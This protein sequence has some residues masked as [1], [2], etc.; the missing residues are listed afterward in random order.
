[1]INHSTKLSP[2]FSYSNGSFLRQC[3]ETTK[4]T[5][6]DDSMGSILCFTIPFPQYYNCICC[7][8][9]IFS[10][11][12]QGYTQYFCFPIWYLCEEAVSSSILVFFVPICACLKVWIFMMMNNLQ[13]KPFNELNLQY[14]RQT[15][16]GKN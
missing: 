15:C 1:M 9:L 6:V 12:L 16:R 8:S 2:V 5:T 7:W 4:L 10:S 3:L 14:W 11:Y 13:G